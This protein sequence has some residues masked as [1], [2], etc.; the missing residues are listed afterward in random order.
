ML[1]CSESSE[2]SDW[3]GDTGGKLQPPKRT[4]QRKRKQRKISSSETEVDSDDLNDAASNETQDVTYQA[5]I[6][7]R[8]RKKPVPKK[9]VPKPTKK[10][11][12]SLRQTN[13]DSLLTISTCPLAQNKYIFQLFLFRSI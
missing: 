8:Q 2:Y 12:V 5:R 10:T 3:M 4:S 11:I 6:P 1:F 9:E 13:I 7:R